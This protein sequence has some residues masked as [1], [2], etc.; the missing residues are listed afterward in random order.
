M[1]VLPHKKGGKK[2]RY[3]FRYQRKRQSKLMQWLFCVCFT[4]ALHCGF[5]QRLL[6][7]MYMGCKFLWFPHGMCKFELTNLRIHW[8]KINKTNFMIKYPQNHWCRSS[9]LIKTHA[10]NLCIDNNSN[11]NNKNIK[12]FHSHFPKDFINKYQDSR[13]PEHHHISV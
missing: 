10:G 12:K 11:N 3:D 1:L 5:I 2:W 4:F 7:L 8:R 6:I 13:T 9:F